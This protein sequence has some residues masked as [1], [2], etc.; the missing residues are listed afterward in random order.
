MTIILKK[1]RYVC[2]HCKKRFYE[3]Y[4][5]IQKYFRKSNELYNKI[6][7]E[8]KQQKSL[9]T[10]AIDNHI[11]I[12]TVNRYIT[13][14]CFLNNKHKIYTFPAHIGID[15]FKGNT[16]DEKYQV[17]I[18]DLD[19]GKVVDI[20]KSRKY[21]D[22]EIY[23]SKITNLKEVKTVSID[24]YSPFRKI[25]KDKIPKAEIVADCFHYTRK[26]IEVLDRCRINVQ[27]NMCKQYRDYFKGIKNLLIMRK[28]DLKWNGDIKLNKAFEISPLLKFIYE[29]KENF[30]KINSEKDPKKKKVMFREWMSYAQ[31]T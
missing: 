26:V 30:L 16:G 29:I 5:F 17:Q 15:E 6:I 28:S 4:S 19:T 8:A 12:P 9:K 3:E 27:K 25:I 14:N 7:Q 11:S 2:C 24:L 22:L 13:Y 10:I 18:S 31:N 21:D 23:L 1:R 20:V